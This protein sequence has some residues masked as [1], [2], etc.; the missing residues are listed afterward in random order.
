MKQV[1]TRGVESKTIIR[2][3][4]VVAKAVHCHSLITLISLDWYLERQRMYVCM[5]CEQDLTT[6]RNETSVH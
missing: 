2:M 3:Y 5:Y 1:Y 4:M 6:S